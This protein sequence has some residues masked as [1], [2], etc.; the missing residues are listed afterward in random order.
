ML[1]VGFSIRHRTRVLDSSVTQKLL[2]C[3][4]LRVAIY[5][6]NTSSSNGINWTKTA[7]MRRPTWRRSWR[8]SRRRTWR[9]RWIRASSR[10]WGQKVGQG[11]SH[12]TSFCGERFTE[13]GELIPRMFA[14]KT[15]SPKATEL[16][17]FSQLLQRYQQVL[18]CIM[19]IIDLRF[20]W[21]RVTWQSRWVRKNIRGGSGQG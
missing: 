20:G 11:I 12:R 6:L 21:H 10:S 9:R 2:S 4:L 17:K 19:R 8:S 15:L 5:A 16:S 18:R 1:K 13:P 7:I 3:T 14:V